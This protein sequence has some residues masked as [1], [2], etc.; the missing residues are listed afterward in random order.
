MGITSARPGS[1]GLALPGHA[2]AIL[3]KNGNHVSP[4]TIVTLVLKQ[5]FLSLARDVWNN[6]ERYVNNY[7]SVFNGY[8]SN[9]DEAVEDE[10]KHIWVLCRTDDVIN[11]A[12]HRLSTMEMEN[13]IMSIPEISSAAVIDIDDDINILIPAVFITL[14]GKIEDSNE[15]KNR[16]RNVIND[17]IGKF[18][19]TGRIYIISEMPKT[20]SG[21]IMR[22]LLREIV[23]NG[24][25][26]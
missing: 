12:G 17:S 26:S 15:I 19:I 16:I 2:Y 3:D 24:Y 11:V 8:Y 22:R 5:P 23:S 9:Y 14:N 7:F 25:I 21:K 18:A 13:S 4:G 6:H 10:Y 20:G 1:C